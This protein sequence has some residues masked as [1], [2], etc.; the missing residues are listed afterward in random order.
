MHAFEWGGA[1]LLVR[2]VEEL[3][4]LT[5][6]RYVEIEMTGMI[7]IINALGGIRLC[8][9]EDVS[10]A[11]R[12]YLEWQ[13][14]CHQADG[15]TAIAFARYRD[16]ETYDD[17]ARSARHRQ[18]VSAITRRI[19]HPA[20]LGY[21]ARHRYFV[22]AGMAAL[23]VDDQTELADF[24]RLALAFRAASGPDGVTGVPPTL[25][26]P[27]DFGIGYVVEFDPALIDQFWADIRYGNLT[28]AADG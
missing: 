27:R 23:R 5:I 25:E 13:A 4:N 26:H 12:N 9:D 16:A 24:A 3:T 15:P 21:P 11:G 8:L 22:A 2:T 28:L 7:E 10:D 18:V 17:V 20:F 6:D 14:G 1:P 19:T